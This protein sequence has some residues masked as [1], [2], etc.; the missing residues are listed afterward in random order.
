MKKIIF[1]YLFVVLM[2]FPRV[3]YA[4]HIA[5]GFLPIKYS[6]FYFLLCVPFIYKGIKDIRKKTVNNKELKMLLGVVTA[7]CFVLS[8]LKIP[9]VT[10]SCSHPTGAGFGAILFGPFVMAVVGMLVLIFQAIF[11][12][13]GGITTLGANTF[14]MGIAGPIVAF[15][16]YELLKKRNKKIAIFL[17]AMLGDLATYVVTATQLGIAFPASDGGIGTSLVKFLGIFAVTQIP[18]AVIEGIITVI[19]FDFIEKYAAADLKALEEV[20]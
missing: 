20:R 4:M 17:A 15:I 14:S 8:A 1:Y 2:F 6:V 5:E 7:F 19:I 10:G 13:H 18:L 9:S 12:A 11:L 16:I 3:A